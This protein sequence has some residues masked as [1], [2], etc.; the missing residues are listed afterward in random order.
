MDCLHVRRRPRILN[1][2][3]FLCNGRNI[4]EW[5]TTVGHNG[6]SVLDAISPPSSAA[7]EKPDSYVQYGSCA[8]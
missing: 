4:R 3:Y 7:H 1:L 2:A 5:C 8:S 6:F